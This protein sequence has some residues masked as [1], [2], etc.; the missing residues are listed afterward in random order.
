MERGEADGTRV[1]GDSGWIL[2]SADMDHRV[3]R[4]DMTTRQVYPFAINR[5]GMPAS[6]TNGDGLERPIDTVFSATGSLYVSDFGQF[7][8]STAIPS[9]GV[10][11]KVDLE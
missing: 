3:S 6:N 11:W 2:S 10:I 7:S 8:G 1:Y 9:T 4:I 5:T